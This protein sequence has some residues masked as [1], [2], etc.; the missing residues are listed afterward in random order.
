M[1]LNDW[2]HIAVS[3]DAGRVAAG[4]KIYVNGSPV[5]T[6]VLMDELNQTFQ[7]KEPFRIGGGGG[8]KYTGSIDDVKLFTRDLD[9][10]EMR[11]LAVLTTVAD[12][13]KKPAA[14][15]SAAES[16]KLHATFVQSTSN[17]GIRRPHEALHKLRDDRHKQLE[18]VP[19]VMVMEEM[20]TPRPTH[21]LLRGDY[22]KKGERVFPGVPET[23]ASPPLATGGLSN[24]LG[25]AK[26]LVDP[27]NPLTARVAVN[28]AGNFTSE[29]GSSRRPKTSAPR[30][31]SPCTP[32]CWTGSPSS[33]SEIGT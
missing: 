19:T 2:T 10:S 1:R 26:W 23:L 7:T 25:F 31:R 8:P 27:T 22:E 9:A 33:S 15:R 29:P 24:R 4:T 6:R 32:S 20:P 30:V 21:V 13:A 5:K 17:K 14:D 12:I 3:Y 16:E 18:S 11:L 28:R